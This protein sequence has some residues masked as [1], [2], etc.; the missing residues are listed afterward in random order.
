[1]EA[2]TLAV[3]HSIVNGITLTFFLFFP[4]QRMV[5]SKGIADKYRKL[6]QVTLLFMVF[7]TGFECV[8]AGLSI[9]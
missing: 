4:W 2:T 6:V 8:S 7:L 9:N 3:I 5:L 1:M